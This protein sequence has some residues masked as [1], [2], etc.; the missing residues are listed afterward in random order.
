MSTFD[1]L[2]LSSS[3]AYVEELELRHRQDPASLDPTWRDLFENGHGST[4]IPAST[5]APTSA[6]LT[7]ASV[8]P[9]PIAGGLDMAKVYAVF[10]MIEEFRMRGHLE[11]NLDPLGMLHRPPVRELDPASWG[12]VAADLDKVY[13]VGDYRGEAGLPLRELLARLRRTYC[14]SIGVQFMT[15]QQTERRDWLKQRMEST[16]NQPNI[17]KAAR[18]TMLEQLGAAEMLEKFIHHKYIGTK[19]FSLEGAETMIPMLDQVIE[20]GAR[21]GAVEAVIGMPHRGRLNVLVNTMHK[22]PRDLFAEFEDIDPVK[23]MGGGDVKYHLGASCDHV[24]RGGKR[25]HLSLAFNPS[26][27][28]VVNPVVAG[29]VRAKQ[30]RRGDDVRQ[31]VVGILLHGDAAFAGQGLVAETL[32]MSEIK[33]YRTGGTVHLIV[34]NQIGFTT[35]PI[36]GRSTTYST[37]IAKMLRCPIFHVNGE[38]PD[39]VAH[40]VQMAMEFRTL[41]KS[42]VVIDMYC[43][44]KYGHNETDEP[45]F[46]QPLIYQRVEKKAHPFDVYMQRL[47]DEGVTTREEVEAMM[48]RVGAKLDEELAAAK[49]REQRPEIP[50]GQ[51]LWTSYVGG[52]DKA[53]PD[54]DTGVSRDRLEQIA[55]GVTTIPE[56]FALNPKVARIYEQRLQ[57]GQGKLAADWGM[58][59]MLAYGSLLLEGSLLR[60][61]G[62]DCS[63]GTFSH[64][65]AVVVDQVNGQEYT[66][67]RHLAPDQAP[68]RVYDSPL[69]EA[70]VLGFEFGY[71]LDFPDGLVIWEAQFGDFVNGAQVVLDQFVSST[72]DK[73]K[74]LSG[75]TLYLPHGFEGQGPEHSSCRFER[76]LQLAAE[77]NIQVCQPTNPAQHF[78]LLRRQV[79]RKIRKPLIVITP[80]SLLR[81]PAAGSPIEDF[82]RGRFERVLADP[83]APEAA[84]VKRLLLC[85]GKVYYDLAEER[86]KRGDTQTAILRFEQLYPWREELITEALKPY[87]K[88]TDVVWVQDEPLNM[89]AAFFVEPRLCK[90]LEQLKV[91][92]RLRVASRLESASPATGSAKAHKLEQEQLIKDAYGA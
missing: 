80:K 69:S 28:E 4:H 5:P 38:D 70:G 72:E 88:A 42:D 81:L 58:G 33:G 41:F 31:Q 40:V 22:S 36:E 19:R 13:P 60:L 71:S 84:K 25:I 14:G 73:W 17:D 45:A 46:T 12:L 26:H 78:H 20:H 18:L 27:L 62:Q 15:A 8:A 66:P 91:K 64:R 86:K 39:A 67:L 48:T 24:T 30:R 37:D 56:G 43:F 55:R 16:Q 87:A 49:K 79:N 9:A 23:A 63:R 74:R 32:N 61:S 50:A 57:M 44:R 2:S 7:R 68:F 10:S 11:A 47:V 76:F 82:T 34:N 85:S 3:L 75:L 54:V 89:G 65:H 53:V 21:L 52:I 29:R 59:E 90:L 92:A 6:A 1:P 83:G 77:D 51:G 35:N